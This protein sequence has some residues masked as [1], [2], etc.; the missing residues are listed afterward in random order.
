MALA[1]TGTALVAK[2]QERGTGQEDGLGGMLKSRARSQIMAM[3]GCIFDRLIS[4]SQ[5]EHPQSEDPGSLRWG[6]HRVS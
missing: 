4:R 1:G 5:G 3:L 6:L 2:T